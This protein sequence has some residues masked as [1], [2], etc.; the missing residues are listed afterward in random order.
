MHQFEH[1]NQIKQNPNP[2]RALTLLCVSFFMVVTDSTSVYAALPSIE[3]SLEFSLGGPEWIII[4]Y[5][6]VFAGLVLLGG[7]ISDYFGRRRMFIIGVIAFTLSAMLCGF[8]WSGKALILA[9]LLQGVSA[10]IM[11]PAALSIVIN[12]FKNEKEKNKAIGIWGAM[13]G[14]GAT[15]GLLIGG[16]TTEWLGWEWIFFINVPIGL[17]VLA[18]AP[19]LLKESN[20]RTITNFDIPGAMLITGFLLIIAY[21][22]TGIPEYGWKSNHTVLLFIGSILL[23]IAFIQVEKKAKEPL[24]PFRIFQSPILVGGNLLMLFAGMSVDGMLYIFTLFVQQLLGYT[25]LQFGL[26][27]TAMTVLSVLGVYVGQHI[28]SRLGLQIVGISGMILLG[29]GM[30]LINI[31]P[32]EQMEWMMLIALSIFGIGMGASF[33]V[34]QI[35]ALSNV[36]DEDSGL[37]SGIVETTFSVGGA[38]GIAILASISQVFSGNPNLETITATGVNYA[39]NMVILFSILGVTITLLF[40]KRLRPT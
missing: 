6:L 14:I 4:I 8:A 22:I 32:V 34:A 38:L 19:I 31:L 3:K 2:W 33:V 16:P 13:G 36:K 26:T 1:P 25:A 5:M 37:A 24:V 12:I 28:I 39:F 30:V 15:G 10:A 35:A 11:T 29:T 9:R 27:M 17:I 20:D 21:V 40:F 7:R 18:L 23:L